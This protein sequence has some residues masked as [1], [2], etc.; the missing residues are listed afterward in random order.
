MCRDLQTRAPV[1]KG[2]IAEETV[3]GEKIT[4][5]RWRRFRIGWRSTRIIRI[6]R[7]VWRCKP[8]GH[9]LQACN[10]YY[11]G[12]LRISFKYLGSE[13][14]IQTVEFTLRVF[15]LRILL[16]CTWATFSCTYTYCALY[17]RET[18]SS[19]LSRC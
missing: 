12:T 5:R 15:I 1:S 14:F 11:Y 3:E 2:E 9:L 16:D 17:F 8:K 6:W 13:Y 18:V 19:R 7:R 10:F 4:P